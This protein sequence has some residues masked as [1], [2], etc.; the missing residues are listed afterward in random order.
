MTGEMKRSF[1]ARI[2]QANRTG[3]VVILYEM[4]DVYLEDALNSMEEES[5]EKIDLAFS[6]V[7]GCI[8][9]LMNSL[10]MEYE[11]AQ[12]MM[13][14]YVFCLKRLV[15]SQQKKDKEVLLWVKNTL[16]KLSTAYAQA[17]KDDNSPPEMIGIQ[18]VYE[19]LTYGKTGRAQATN[20]YK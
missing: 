12:N 7:R 18:N 5:Q 13:S 8:N 2:S 20:L 19:G 6:R 10:Y 15:Y 17:V 16:K 4:T 3:L 11:M 14:L 1:V 9:E